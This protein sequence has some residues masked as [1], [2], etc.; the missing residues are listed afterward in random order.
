M[1]TSGLLTSSTQMPPA[2]ST[3]CIRVYQSSWCQC[4]PRSSQIRRQF[5]AIVGPA[6]PDAARP[7]PGE[8]V[9]RGQQEHPGPGHHH[10]GQL[11]QAQPGVGQ[12]LQHVAAG[13]AVEAGVGKGQPGQVG[14]H[15]PR[16]AAL[17]PVPGPPQHLV[18]QVE[19]GN[20]ALGVGVLQDMPGELARPAAHVQDVAGAPRGRTSARGTAA[21]P[22]A[23]AATTCCKW[24]AW[25]PAGRRRRGGPSRGTPRSSPA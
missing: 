10:P 11:A 14:H 4:K 24:P 6:A 16:P 12:V 8:I 1:P 19:T 15:E 20:S 3:L 9:L 5:P 18:R 2:R 22:A 25:P 23:C 21:R 7:G 13:D 17:Q